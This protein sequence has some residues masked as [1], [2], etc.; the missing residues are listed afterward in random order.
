LVSLF[1]SFIA[2]II[3]YA[4]KSSDKSLDLSTGKKG[5]IIIAILDVVIVILGVV[6]A[7]TVVGC[8]TRDIYHY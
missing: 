6:L 7:V 3:V 8:A 1:F 2:G 4:I 5:L